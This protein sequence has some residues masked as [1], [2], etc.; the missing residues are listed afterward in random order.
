[1]AIQ[2]PQCGREYDVTLFQF[3]RTIHCTCGTRVGLEKRLGPPVTSS[4]PRF[5][6]DG[7][8]GGLAR[9]LR[10]LGYDAAYDPAIPDKELV[11]RSLSEGRHIL[12]RDRALPDEWRI[13]ACTILEV[14]DSEGQLKEVIQRFNL[15]AGDRLFSRCTVCN[16]LLESVP[17]E[18]ARSRVPP[19]VFELHDVYA[20]CPNCHRIYWEGSHTERMRARLKAILGD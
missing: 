8:L 15:E 20:R 7:M 13:T 5:I 17:R 1:M 19:R 12:T 3:G 18:E 16:S 2:C 4:E 6:V 10:I 14:E 11:R 9:W